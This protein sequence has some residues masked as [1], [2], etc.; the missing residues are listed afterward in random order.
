MLEDPDPKA[1]YLGVTGLNRWGGEYRRDKALAERVVSALEKETAKPFDAEFAYVVGHI[2]PKESG[3]GDRVKALA[4][5]DTTT[6]DI[7]AVLTTWWAGDTSRD[8]TFAYDLVK[9]YSTSSVPRLKR[10]A[11]EGMATFFDNHT[12]EACKLWA[13][14]IANPDAGTAQQSIGMLTG[15]WTGAWTGDEDGS[16][17]VTG[18]GGGPSLYND[19]RCPQVDQAIDIVMSKAKA[20]TIDETKYL[21]SMGFIVSDVKHA[22]PAQRKKAADALK[23][24]VE[25]KGI[26]HYYRGFAL[27]Q[28][29]EKDPS[30]KGYAAKLSGDKDLKDDAKSA[31]EAADKAKK[32]ADEKAKKEAAEKKGKKP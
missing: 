18:G 25:N 9:T 31:L 2:D 1:R 32:D 13:D 5:K 24:T 7:K 30:Q 8:N 4:L 23:A 14:N 12:D 29:C 28:L 15:G 17:Y 3:L 26:G 10:A 6:N 20:G 16:W 22:T 21:Y 19:K 27:R 11:I